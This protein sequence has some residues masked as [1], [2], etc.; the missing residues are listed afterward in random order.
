[1]SIS[2]RNSGNHEDLDSR[3]ARAAVLQATGVRD[4]RELH[5]PVVAWIVLAHI[6]T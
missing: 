5:G 6:V 2:C 4:A 1:M 3:K